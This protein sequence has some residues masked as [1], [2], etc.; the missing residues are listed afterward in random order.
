LREAV[1]AGCGAAL[2]AGL[3]LGAQGLQPPTAARGTDTVFTAA[4]L[5]DVRLALEL[6]HR[7]N[8]HYPKRLDDLVDD[9][10]IGREQLGTR[11]ALLHYRP[12][13]ER[14]DYVLDVPRDR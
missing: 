5:R 6:Y 7:E 12:D 11:D 8:G 9:R 3:W 14:D 13:V 4:R 1:A 10:W 2:F